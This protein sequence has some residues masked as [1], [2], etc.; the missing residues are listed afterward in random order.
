MLPIE[1]KWFADGS[2]T[3]C[4]LIENQS[5]MVADFNNNGMLY[6]LSRR[7]KQESVIGNNPSMTELLHYKCE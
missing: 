7:T 2:R 5:E 1:P 6:E 3:M 4:D